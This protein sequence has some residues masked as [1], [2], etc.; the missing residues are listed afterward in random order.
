[1]DFEDLGIE[2]IILIVAVL[3]IIGVAG[4]FLIKDLNNKNIEENETINTTNNMNQETNE[5]KIETLKEGQGNSAQNGDVVSVHYVGTLENGI[6]FDSSL[7]RGQPFSFTLGA[8]QVI[9]GWDLGVIGM[10]I[11]EKRKLIIP[12]D[13]AYGDAGIPQAGIPAKATLIFEVELLAIN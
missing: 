1:M 6:K 11:G 3:F 5:L 13:F 12:S 7:D 2:K 8:G 4:F 10:K 9:K